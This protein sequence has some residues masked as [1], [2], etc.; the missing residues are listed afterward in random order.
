MAVQFKREA[1]PIPFEKSSADL[2]F[3]MIHNDRSGRETKDALLRIAIKLTTLWNGEKLSLL[4]RE[5]NANDFQNK[6]PNQDKPRTS[7]SVHDNSRSSD[8]FAYSCG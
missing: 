8:K 6:S 1:G 5:Q 3:E 4:N 7:V 2:N